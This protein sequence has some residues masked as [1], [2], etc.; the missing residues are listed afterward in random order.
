MFRGTARIKRFQIVQLVPEMMTYIETFTSINIVNTTKNGRRGARMDSMLG[1]L[2]GAGFPGVSNAHTSCVA[3][4]TYVRV[5][6]CNSVLGH[7]TRGPCSLFLQVAERR[8]VH[9]F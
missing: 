7:V 6:V 3:P 2:L 1:R 4:R 9:L 8:V 5:L